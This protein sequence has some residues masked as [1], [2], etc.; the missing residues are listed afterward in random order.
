M[1]ETETPSIPDMEVPTVAP[2]WLTQDILRL[3]RLLTWGDY[4]I[5]VAQTPDWDPVADGGCTEHL[6][7]DINV[8]PCLAHAEQGLIKIIGRVLMSTRRRTRLSGSSLTRDITFCVTSRVRPMIRT[9]INA[10]TI[11]LCGS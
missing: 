9:V 10:E 1:N 8:A 11:S 7:V 5:D 2:E 6:G 3:P 4:L